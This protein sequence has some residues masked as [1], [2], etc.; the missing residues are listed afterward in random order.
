M[1]A[2]SIW[3]MH[4]AV[5]LAGCFAAQAGPLAN[6]P[7]APWIPGLPIANSFAGIVEFNSDPPGAEATTSLGGGCRTPCSLEVS[8]EGPFTVT[9]THEGYESTTVQVK[10]QHARMGVSDRKFAPNPVFAQLASVAS[11]ALAPPQTAPKKPVATAQPRQ[12]APRKPIAAAQPAAR[13]APARP[14]WPAEEKPAAGI[15]AGPIVPADAARSNAQPPQAAPRKPAA[16]AQPAAPPA[17]AQPAWPTEAKPIAGINS[18]PI[19][20]PAAPRSSDPVARRWLENF[21]K[22]ASD[23]AP[24]KK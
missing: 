15:S 23:Q 9:F 1:R 10:I 14:A 20:P 7:D 5:L 2:A 3:G 4:C 19:V 16:A 21:D 22:P 11:P 12:A 6:D 8:A 18:G 13:P 24:D 17:P